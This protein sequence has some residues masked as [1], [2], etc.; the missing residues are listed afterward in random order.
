MK[1]GTTHICIDSGP[2]M[3]FLAQTVPEIWRGSQ[4]SITRSRDPFPTTFDLI[5]HLNFS[6]V[7]LVLPVVNQ[8]AKFEVSSSNRSQDM[9]GSQNFKSRSRDPFQPLWPNFSFLSLVPPVV[10]LHAKFEVSSSN[11]SQDMER[12]QNFKSRSRDPF[13][14]PFDLIFHFCR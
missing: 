2:E 3:K 12:S 4:I 8:H 14:T 6:F 11:R 10:N 9:E 1:F 13:P 5:F 7:S